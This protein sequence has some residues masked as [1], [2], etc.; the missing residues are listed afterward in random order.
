MK[1]PFELRKMAQV[2]F[3]WA[4]VA[5][6][7]LYVYTWN[8]Q[9]RHDRNLESLASLRAETGRFR[10]AMRH[11]QRLL[12]STRTEPF[13]A[14]M[15]PVLEQTAR[16]RQVG[17]TDIRPTPRQAYANY[18]SIG[19]SCTVTGTYDAVEGFL[20]DVEMARVVME[21]G[22]LEAEL[23]TIEESLRKVPGFS[24]DRE[25][26]VVQRRA[27]LQ[28]EVFAALRATRE[29]VKAAG[30]GA[31]PE[32]RE[33]IQRLLFTWVAGQSLLLE[34]ARERLKER[35]DVV[36][37]IDRIYATIAKRSVLMR[38]GQ[39]ELT[40]SANQPVLARMRLDAF[41]R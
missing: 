1:I 16:A 2:G 21:P 26:P 4:L 10:E 36:Q 41:T 12:P 13:P 27:E 14:L 18:A 28:R 7:V 39:L 8:E 19:F 5:F 20:A 35:A 33:T 23:A 6:P 30:P 3:L 37:K 29:R 32:D 9:D 15:I 25:S 11:F 22:Q 40:G 34:A 38:V 31:S 17:L 24:I